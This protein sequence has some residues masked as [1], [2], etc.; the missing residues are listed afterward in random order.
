MTKPALGWGAYCPAGIGLG[1]SGLAGTFEPTCTVGARGEGLVT[2]VG[3][4]AV[5]VLGG[6]GA[7]AADGASSGSVLPPARAPVVPPTW[8]AAPPDPLYLR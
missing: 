6:G 1:C 7:A 5:F 8:I 3:V 4:F 2:V